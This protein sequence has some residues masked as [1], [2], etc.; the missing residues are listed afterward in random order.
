MGAWAGSSAGSSSDG[1][2]SRDLDR[3]ELGRRGCIGPRSR[4][5]GAGG[6]STPADGDDGSD[7]LGGGVERRERP[8][9]GI[10]SGRQ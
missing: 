6:T 5:A 1:N 4:P 10:G 9:R 7:D 3:P 2:T 8:E